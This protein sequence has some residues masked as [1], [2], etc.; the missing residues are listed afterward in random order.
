MV[1]RVR[2]RTIFIAC[3]VIILL[4]ALVI[5]G[6]HLIP[7]A[8]GGPTGVPGTPSPASY[9][10]QVSMDVSYGPQSDE[11]LDQCLPVGAPSS[12]PGIVMIHGGSWNGGDKSKYD[13]ICR[14]FAA[15]GYV[16]TTINY[17]LTPRY[18]WPDQIGD[19]QLAVRYLRANASRLGLN[20][21]RICSLGDSAGSQLALLLDELQSIHPADVASLYPNVSPAVQCVVD[22]FGPT[23]LAQLY[24]ANPP[25]QQFIYALLDNQVPPAPIYT[26]ASPLD[27]ITDQTGRALIIQGTQD[28]TVLPDQSQELYQAFLHAGI[29]AHY[30][31]YNGDH[32]YRGLSQSQFTSMLNQINTFLN[33]VEPPGRR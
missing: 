7:Q 10:V 15:E 24:S 26:D 20:P 17:R 14:Y 31:S 6:L 8:G 9:H 13:A 3:C 23:N 12:R 21:A 22:Q 25:V 2:M 16:A 11:V 33:A 5:L 27:H 29:A 1:R 19:A 28:Q 30:I 18:Q 4:I 32:E